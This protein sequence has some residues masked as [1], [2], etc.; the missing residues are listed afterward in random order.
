MNR[1]LT[2]RRLIREVCEEGQK[3]V[4]FRAKARRSLSIVYPNGTC[5]YTPGHEFTGGG[6]DFDGVLIAGY[7]ASGVRLTWMH[8][9]GLTDII[10]KDDYDCQAYDE[11]RQGIMKTQYPHI[12]GL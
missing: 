6:E 2:H 9:E 3:D 5:E 4:V 1:T 10:V 12:E 7:P 11:N 8:V